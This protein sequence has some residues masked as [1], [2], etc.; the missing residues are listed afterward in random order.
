MTKEE[1]KL[2]IGMLATQLTLTAEIVNTL[3][4]KGTLSPADF[5]RIW[6]AAISTGP[7]KKYFYD[8]VSQLYVGM[9]KTLGVNVG[10]ESEPPAAG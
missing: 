10:L 7:E 6:K 4:D 9:A 5:Q 1:H 8:Q 2:L 3:K